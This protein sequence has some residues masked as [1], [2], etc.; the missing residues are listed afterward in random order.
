MNMIILT[1][2]RGNDYSTDIK[3]DISQQIACKELT[4]NI[5]DN[6]NLQIAK[7]NK[8][9]RACAVLSC[10]DQMNLEEPVLIV[11][12]EELLN[13][14]V[15]KMLV[16]IQDADCDAVITVTENL[17]KQ[18]EDRGIKTDDNH[19]VIEIIDRTCVSDLKIVEGYYFKVAS[20]FIDSACEMIKK[21]PN[22]ARGYD[23]SISL[24]E[25][26]LKQ[27]KIAYYKM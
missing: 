9:G 10:I 4:K 24:N 5:T 14:P 25:M 1:D 7:F 18:E 13:I 26:I 8:K 16:M 2:E 11:T 15:S 22:Y 3:N 23:I 20:D 27:K 19:H 21:K 12:Y 17:E 6:L